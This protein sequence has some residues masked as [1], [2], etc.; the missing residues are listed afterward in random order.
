[1][2]RSR[3][4]QPFEYA[5]RHPF[6]K[7]R[8]S[9]EHPRD[10]REVLL[11]LAAP[12]LRIGSRPDFTLEDVFDVR[13]AHSASEHLLPMRSLDERQVPRIGLYLDSQV[14]ALQGDSD[15]VGKRLYIELMFERP[16]KTFLIIHGDD[17]IEIEAHERFHV[18]VDRLPA[19]DAIPD[20]PVLEEP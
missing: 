19:D 17:E 9:F 5:V 20:R 10:V 14:G 6:A 15:A 1:M 18:G 4:N 3:S 13:D 11:P 16:R 12:A 7:R 8:I 2:N